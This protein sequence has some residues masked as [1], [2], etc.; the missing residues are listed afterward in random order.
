VV[1][2]PLEEKRLALAIRKRNVTLP[3]IACKIS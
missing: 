3:K 2:K 1:V